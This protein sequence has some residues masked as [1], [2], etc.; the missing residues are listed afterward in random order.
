[1]LSSLN[2]W[3]IVTSLITSSLKAKA[4]PNAMPPTIITVLAARVIPTNK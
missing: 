2:F 4:I 1:M 3:S